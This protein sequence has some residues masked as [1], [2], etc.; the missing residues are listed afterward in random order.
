MEKQNYN[1]TLTVYLVAILVDVLN[2]CYG[3]NCGLSLYDLDRFVQNKVIP[4]FK[5]YDT[6]FNDELNLVDSIYKYFDTLNL[7]ELNDEWGFMN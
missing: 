2:K 5:G 7:E 1:V 3:Y 6:N 4:D